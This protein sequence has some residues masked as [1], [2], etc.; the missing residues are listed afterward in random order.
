MNKRRSLSAGAGLEVNSVP[1]LGIKQDD[2][3]VLLVVVSRTYEVP[4]QFSDFVGLIQQARRRL[5]RL[6]YDGPRG[7]I[8]AVAPN[9]WR[10]SVGLERVEHVDLPCLAA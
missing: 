8:K 1:V 6:A 9:G 4:R 2:P 3:K 7:E 10:C 5:L